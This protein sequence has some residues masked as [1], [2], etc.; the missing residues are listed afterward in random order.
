VP[1]HI[2]E[3]CLGHTL[4]RIA[5]IYDTHDYL[6]ERREALERWARHVLDLVGT[7]TP[8]AAA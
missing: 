1:P 4:G 3:T 8:R 7:A 6:E 5:A 2:A